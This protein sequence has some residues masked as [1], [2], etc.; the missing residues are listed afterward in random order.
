MNPT[1]TFAVGDLVVDSDDDDP[2]P[3]IVVNTPPVTAGNWDIGRRTVATY[4]GNEQ[5]SSAAAVVLVVYRDD[6][7]QWRPEYDGGEAIPAAE[8]ARAP[9]PFYAFPAPRLEPAEDS[10]DSE[11]GDPLERI[12]AELRERR[13]DSVEVDRRRDIVRV[14]KLGIGYEIAQDGTVN[15][16]DGLAEEIEEIAREAVEATKEVVA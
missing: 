12:A 9:V 13:V 16:N 4:P 5:Y 3:A 1:D 6:L 14:E 15:R 11:G 10:D 8:L 2:S 7:E